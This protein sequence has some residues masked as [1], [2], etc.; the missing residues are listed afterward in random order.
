MHSDR[1]LIY[2]GLQA[3]RSDDFINSTA[4]DTRTFSLHVL[5]RAGFG[6]SYQF[7][8]VKDN[9]PTQGASNYKESLRTIL[10]NCILL[11]ILGTKFLSVKWLPS[12]LRKLHQATVNLKQYMTEVYEKEKAAFLDR[13]ST[14]KNLMTSLICA[15]ASQESKNGS[16]TDMAGLT[17]SEIY[18]N[19]FIFNF[20]G[21]DTDTSKSGI[22]DESPIVPQSG[23]FIAWSEGVRV[24][25]GK[26]FSQIEFVAAMAGILR[27]W[28]VDP[29]PVRNRSETMVGA[30]E[31]VM[32]LVESDTGQ[33]LLLQMLHHERAP[34][35]WKK[36]A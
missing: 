12:K 18:S 27:E 17:E 28:R 2:K 29:V 13:K 31:R 21:H 33:V 36:R 19:I 23:S 4:D 11:M 24:C 35:A 34:L 6:K 10:N 25:P 9:C 8:G 15:R 14:G 7:Q 32:K 22:G 20:A 3:W 16:D 1:R 5:S 30:R 26:K